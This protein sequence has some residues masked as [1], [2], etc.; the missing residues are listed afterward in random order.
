LGLPRCNGQ[1][2]CSPGASWGKDDRSRVAYVE[3]LPTLHQHDAIGFLERAVAWFATHGVR[4]ESVM[5]DN[6]SAY[7]ARA[8]A[9][10]CAR[11]RV[12]HLRTRPYTPRTNGKAERFI[13]TLLREWA[14]RRAYPTSRRRRRALAPWL[15]YY[16]GRRPHTALDY[17]PPFTRLQTASV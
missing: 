3:V 7:L 8:F 1:T 12:R 16:N 11:L 17:R 15:R 13:Q 5:T 4:A 14:Y 2:R 9:A 10:T 6:G